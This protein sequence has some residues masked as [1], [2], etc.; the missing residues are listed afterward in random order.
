MDPNCVQSHRELSQFA[1]GLRQ[2]LLERPD[3]WENDTLESY[4]EAMSGW[5]RA[6]DGWARNHM[7]PFDGEASWELFAHILYSAVIYE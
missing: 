1:F 7:V 4:L 2:D 3:G 6:L 5:T